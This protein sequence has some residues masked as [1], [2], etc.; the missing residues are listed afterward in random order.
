MDLQPAVE[1]WALVLA[2]VSPSCC[3]RRC[4]GVWPLW[5]HR[6][7]CGSKLYNYLLKRLLWL[8]SL[9]W[10]SEQRWYLPL[11]LHVLFFP[12]LPVIF[13]PY[14]TFGTLRVGQKEKFSVSSSLQK[15]AKSWAKPESISVTAKG[16][17][18]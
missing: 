12:W 1:S 2:S 11:E 9:G 13:S 15:K 18:T 16:P 6:L 3:P 5:K 17:L 8:A 4:F 14:L 10:H 7:F